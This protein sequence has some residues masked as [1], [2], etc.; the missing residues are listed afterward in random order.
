MG[1]K[2]TPKYNIR[3]SDEDRSWTTLARNANR[4]PDKQAIYYG[5]KVYTYRQLNEEVN[6]LA[7]GLLTHGISKG[8]KLAVLMI[9]IVF[10]AIMKVGAIAVPINYRLAKAEVKYIDEEYAANVAEIGK[11]NQQLL[12]QVSANKNI[13]DG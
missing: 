3:G 4:H 13:V 5:E 12:L 11:E 2:I 8:D 1:E 7:H 10:Y 9:M 6:R